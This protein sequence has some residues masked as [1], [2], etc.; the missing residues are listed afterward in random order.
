[1]LF[2]RTDNRIDDVL[3]QNHVALTMLQRLDAKL[4]RIAAR[5]LTDAEIRSHDAPDPDPRTPGGILLLDLLEHLHRSAMD[6]M[7]YVAEDLDD[8]SRL[9][10]QRECVATDDAVRIWREH[11]LRMDHV[12]QHEDRM[13]RLALV[14]RLERLYPGTETARLLR[15]DVHD[16]G[17][18]VPSVPY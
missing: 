13:V 8:A 5:V 6:D 14:E 9:E 17:T 16:D 1:M 3:N 18:I 15:D 11:C 10:L 7:A 4:D 2:T 12:R